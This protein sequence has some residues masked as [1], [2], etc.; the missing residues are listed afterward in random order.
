MAKWLH[1]HWKPLFLGAQ[2]KSRHSSVRLCKLGTSSSNTIR[3]VHKVVIPSV[4]F[5]I[6]L[7]QNY[8]GSDEDEDEEMG[9]AEGDDD[10]DA[11]LDE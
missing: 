1:R 11:E 10:E 8:A 3:F 2:M 9:D 5:S 6:G 7:Y 4:F